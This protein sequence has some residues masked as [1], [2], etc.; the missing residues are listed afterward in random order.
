LTG[1]HGVDA[2]GDPGRRR[3]YTRT[4]DAVIRPLRETDRPAVARLLDDAVGAGFWRFADDA[5]AGSFVAV[6]GAPRGE[7]TGVILT[8]LEPA[9]DPDVRT[10]LKGSSG[11]AAESGELVLHIRQLAVAPAARRTGVASRLMARAE[12]EALARG[13][14]AAFA[15]GWLPAGRPEPDAVPFYVAAGYEA[16]PVVRD[17]YA[18]SSVAAGAPCP[19]CG[20]PPCRCAARPFVKALGPG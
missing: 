16:R 7:V 4:V 14:K 17:F 9:D 18:E 13:A 6:S 12:A 10:A 2:A 8:C 11:S 15:F 3:R 19:Y 20:E 1:A 5:G